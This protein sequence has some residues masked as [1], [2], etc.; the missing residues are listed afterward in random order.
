MGSSRKAVQALDRI[1][2]VLDDGVG[3]R[4]LQ[5]TPH[6]VLLSRRFYDESI[7]PVLCQWLVPSSPS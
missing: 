7:R 3:R 5:T 6:L 4:L 1:K 2:T